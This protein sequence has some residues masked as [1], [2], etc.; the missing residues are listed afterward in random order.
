MSNK[1]GKIEMNYIDYTR[2]PDRIIFTK[3]DELDS[4]LEVKGFL[5]GGTYKDVFKLNKDKYVLVILKVNN[6]DNSKI[7]SVLDSEYEGFEQQHIFS[8]DST[9]NYGIPRIYEYGKMIQKDIAYNSNEKSLYYAIMENAGNVN[10]KYLVDEEYKKFNSGKFSVFFGKKDLVNFVNK[11]NSEQQETV[12]FTRKKI[13]YGLLKSL[14]IIHDNGY[15]HL[16][17]KL[18]QFVTKDDDINKIKLLDFGFT[19]KIGEKLSSARGTPGYLSPVLRY[20]KKQDLIAEPCMDI[21]S[22]GVC[23]LNIIIG[24][25]TCNVG[26]MRLIK[27]WGCAYKK[28]RIEDIIKRFLKP[29]DLISLTD[30]ERDNLIPMIRR[31]LMIT[32]FKEDKNNTN[33][34][35]DIYGDYCC[36][37]ETVKEILKEP[38]FNDT[39]FNR[40]KASLEN[41]EDNIQI[42]TPMDRK[43]ILELWQ[44][45]K[46]LLTYLKSFKRQNNKKNILEKKN[47]KKNLIVLESRQSRKNSKKNKIILQSRPP[48]KNIN[49]GG[50]KKYKKSKRKIQKKYLK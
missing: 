5:A 30:Y 35:G 22:L 36:R 15:I 11:S 24:K 25:K 38:Y 48:K 31:M 18:E 39:K 45:P 40:Y 20:F 4:K 32:S 29:N 27:V 2:N 16:D 46:K 19:N 47:T 3:D 44:R 10:L 14:Q 42:Q 21:F 33:C 37:Y 50:G 7:K 1:L 23:F 34:K 6:M 17:I 49:I 12:S 43:K 9:E 8:K 26:F 28:Q 41:P 13:F